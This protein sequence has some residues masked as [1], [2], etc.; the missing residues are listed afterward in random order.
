MP[1]PSTKSVKITI[2]Q[3][4][5]RRLGVAAG[6]G[7]GEARAGARGGATQGPV[8]ELWNGPWRSSLSGNTNLSARS[9]A[10]RRAAIPCCLAELVGW[11]YVGGAARAPQP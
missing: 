9:Q 8:G 6:C 1:M 4:G 2:D 11:A 5:R 3:T 7:A 10:V